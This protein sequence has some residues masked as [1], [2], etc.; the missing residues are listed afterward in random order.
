MRRFY[1]KN[2]GEAVEARFLDAAVFLGFIVAK[3][4]GESRPFD[5][6]VAWENNSR[7]YRIQVKASSSRH[8]KSGY[9]FKSSHSRTQR[10][11]TA[12]EID[13]LAAYIVPLKIWYIVPVRE[14]CKAS[15]F[16]VFPAIRNSK[17]KYE[18]YREQWDLLRR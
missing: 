14:I 11:Y 8:G 17:S 12:D 13:F 18:R 2:L 7:P 6:Y 4:W 15:T 5:F 1:P 10:P 16:T 3:L 9:K